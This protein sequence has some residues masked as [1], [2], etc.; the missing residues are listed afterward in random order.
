MA[1]VRSRKFCCCL[2]VRFGVFVMS[3]FAMLFGGAVAV[4][5]W[6]QVIHLKDQAVIA[7][8]EKYSLIANAVVWSLISL[9]SIFGFIGTIIKNRSFVS[10]YSTMLFV[11][12]GFNIGS[13]ILYIH[14]LFQSDVEDRNINQCIA[15]STSTLKKETCRAGFK[16]GRTVLIVVYIVVWLFMLYGCMIVANY[17]GQL[18]EEEDLDNA[19]AISAP[20]PVAPAYPQ[21]TYG[22]YN[23]A[24]AMTQQYPYAA[25]QNSFGKETYV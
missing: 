6:V 10:A 21:T 18:S 2:P 14:S 17:V 4:Y 16:V 12:L 20:A 23:T 1:Y 11:L 24:P 9:A 13:G 19:R 25:P 3:L 15:G 7:N 22:E 5:A 8:R